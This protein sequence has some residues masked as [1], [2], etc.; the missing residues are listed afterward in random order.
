MSASVV[1]MRLDGVGKRFDGRW[2][3]RGI[4]LDLTTGDRLAVIG[5]N[6]SGKSTLLRLLCGFARPSEGRLTVT[7]NDASVS[8]DDLPFLA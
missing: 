1:R 2:V 3:L 5:P 4:D 7:R 6:G 8:D